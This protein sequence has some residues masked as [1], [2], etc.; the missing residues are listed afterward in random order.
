[1]M[2]IC[3]QSNMVKRVGEFIQIFGDSRKAELI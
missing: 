3:P 1:M 2:Q